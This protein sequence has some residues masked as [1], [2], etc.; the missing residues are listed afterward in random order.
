MRT[1]LF[2]VGAAVMS[3]LVALGVRKFIEATST[4]REDRERAADDHE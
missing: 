1:M 3:G 2:L 4:I